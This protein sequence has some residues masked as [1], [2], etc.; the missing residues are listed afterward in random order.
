[1][2]QLDHEVS[3]KLNRRLK[4]V[5][6]RLGTVRELD[7]LL[8][9]ID[10][11]HVSG[12]AGSAALGRVGIA[13]AMDRDEARKRL[14]ARLPVG[15]M[16]RLG[17][18]LDR[19]VGELRVTEAAASKTIARQWRWAMDAQLAARASHLSAAVAYAGALY[20]PERLHGVRIAVKKLRYALE[21][22]IEAAGEKGGADLRALKRTQ[23]VLGRMHDLQV[24]TDRVR[25]VQAS[26]APPNVT[27]WRDL[28]ALLA[29]L[30]DDCRR[31][32][33]RYMHVRDALAS[34]ADAVTARPQPAPPLPATRRAG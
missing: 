26:L 16:R 34:I 10:E 14:F 21:L 17:R 23:D 2:L 5:T 33:A 31:L 1:M 27:V 19:V 25:Q 32:H 7:V 28:D 13:V 9:L 30:E 20:L 15:D 3:R 6:T 29:S 18:K 11:L 12:R 24:L 4:K 22:S 8:L